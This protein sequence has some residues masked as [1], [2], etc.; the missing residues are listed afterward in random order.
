MLVSKTN[1]SQS[2][3]PLTFPQMYN[4]S[5]ILEHRNMPL[6][7]AM[8]LVTRNYDRYI[9]ELREKRGLV[10]SGETTAKVGADGQ[11]AATELT[12]TQ[13]FSLL[14]DGRQLTLAEV[15]RVI[16]FLEEMRNRMAED[17]GV[18]LRKKEYPGMMK[19]FVFA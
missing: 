5:T 11:S 15:D 14:A 8:N 12:L 7:D 10:A 18:S 6:E 1:I 19:S 16:T 9:L 2:V 13:L 4:F 3:F 17:Q